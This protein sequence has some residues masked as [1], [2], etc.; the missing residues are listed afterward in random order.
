MKFYYKTLS[1]FNE[2]FIVND[3]NKCILLNDYKKLENILPHLKENITFYNIIYTNI[4]RECSN[5]LLNYGKSKYL[6]DIENGDF[7]EFNIFLFHIAKYLINHKTDSVYYTD[8]LIKG[9]NLCYLLYNILNSPANN[10]FDFLINSFLLSNNNSFQDKFVQYSIENNL[11]YNEYFVQKYVFKN[12]F[13]NFLDNNLIDVNFKTMRDIS[14]DKFNRYIQIYE[15]GRNHNQIFMFFKKINMNRFYENT[16]ILSYDNISTN[17]TAWFRFLCKYSINPNKDVF[18]YFNKNNFKAMKTSKQREF[19]FEV[20]LNCPKILKYYKIRQLIFSEIDFCKELIEQ[21]MEKDRNELFFNFIS[22]FQLYILNNIDNIYNIS[23]IK[24]S[25]QDII[26]GDDKEMV[27][28]NI[29]KTTMI[30]E[31]YHDLLKNKMNVLCD[32]DFKRSIVLLES[33]QEKLIQKINLFNQ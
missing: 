30:L 9:Y 16:E 26:Y 8:L 1:F 18:H 5:V 11:K 24:E 29:N 15:F 20:I 4:T 10:I 25:L 28:E 2:T 6:K 13:N 3:I 19:Y 33:Y 27:L 23:K 12:I 22:S 17:T 31:T 21:M 32:T 14:I 7:E